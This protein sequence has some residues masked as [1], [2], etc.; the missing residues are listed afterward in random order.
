MGELHSKESLTRIRMG[1]YESADSDWII[2]AQDEEEMKKI[3]STASPSRDSPIIGPKSVVDSLEDSMEGLEKAPDFTDGERGNS[4][5]GERL[6]RFRGRS[7]TQESEEEVEIFSQL[8]AEGSCVFPSEG[9]VSNLQKDKKLQCNSPSKAVIKGDNVEILGVHIPSG[10]ERVSPDSSGEAT[11]SCEDNVALGRSGKAQP[12]SG[13]ALLQNRAKQMMTG[14]QNMFT[15]LSSYMPSTPSITARSVMSSLAANFDQLSSS[16]VLHTSR[17]SPALASPSPRSLPTNLSD[18]QIPGAAVSS[19]QSPFPSD[20]EMFTDLEMES[21]PVDPTQ[22]DSIGSSAALNVRGTLVPSDSMQGVV[23]TQPPRVPP[24]RSL[25]KFDH[26]ESRAISSGYQTP[27]MVDEADANA[28]RNEGTGLETAEEVRETSSGPHRNGT[29]EFETQAVV[30]NV[31]RRPSSLTSSSSSGI[32]ETPFSTPVSPPGPCAAL[33]GGESSQSLSSAFLSDTSPQQHDQS[34]RLSTSVKISEDPVTLSHA[35]V[36]RSSMNGNIELPNNEFVDLRQCVYNESQQTA[37]E[38]LEAKVPYADC[39]SE[40]TPGNVNDE[41]LEPSSLPTYSLSTNGE[42]ALFSTPAEAAEFSDSALQ[43]FNLTEHNITDKTCI[44]QV[45]DSKVSCRIDDTASTT[46]PLPETVPAA[47]TSCLQTLDMLSP[48]TPPAPPPVISANQNQ[49]SPAP[50][51]SIICE[52]DIHNS[53]PFPS[54]PPTVTSAG[55]HQASPSPQLAIF[56]EMDTSSGSPASPASLPRES[57]ELLEDALNSVDLDELDEHNPVTDNNK[58]GP[59]MDNGQQ[60]S[61]DSM[62]CDHTSPHHDKPVS[63]LKELLEILCVFFLFCLQ[64]KVIGIH[65]ESME[66]G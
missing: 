51:L 21:D 62:E 3:K 55:Q 50:D 23:E 25:S 38:I 20:V 7:E 41:S 2:I 57:K 42:N 64:C 18:L 4:Q 33:N 26:N 49:S 56:C 30:K 32:F 44:D 61:K 15:S 54:A 17:S 37:G 24:L 19:T 58:H 6:L 39:L 53:S 16:T 5:R 46:P 36:S 52:K 35:H 11:G 10:G 28:S 8:L 40:Q 14:A 29:E 63:T 13:I 48:K 65:T 27:G 12:S 22:S 59:V 47:T 45:S 31:E 43:N 1:S 60:T 34:Q 9:E 66:E